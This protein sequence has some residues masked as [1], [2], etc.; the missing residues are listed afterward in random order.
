[1]NVI[2]LAGKTCSGK[3]PFARAVQDKLGFGRISL[4]DLYCFYARKD[5]Q[6]FDP[7]Q[8]TLY[9]RDWYKKHRPQKDYVIVEGMQVAIRGERE[10]I[11]EL[12]GVTDYLVVE[13]ENVNQYENA[14]AQ[15]G[16]TR[17]H[18]IDRVNKRYEKNR[19]LGDYKIVTNLEDFIDICR[20]FKK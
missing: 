7:G 3:T 4:D 11:R 6:H 19:Q 17:T 2:F 1:M 12:W 8:D 16:G 15:Y 9:K 20:G 14:K 10:L 5:K 18:V 13:I